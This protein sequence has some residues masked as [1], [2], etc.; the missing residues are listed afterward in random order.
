V[1]QQK[2]FNLCDSVTSRGGP[3]SEHVLINWRQRQHSESHLL[4]LPATHWSLCLSIQEDRVPRI[5]FGRLASF[6]PLSIGRCGNASGLE[7]FGRNRCDV[8]WRRGF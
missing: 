6:L 3:V 4:S 1:S 8:T 7:V 5:D 2:H